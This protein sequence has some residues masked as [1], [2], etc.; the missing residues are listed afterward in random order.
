MLAAN[1]YYVRRRPFFCSS[2]PFYEY[3]CDCAFRVCLE[4]NFGSCA[5]IN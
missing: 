3:K 2:S 4:F 5:Y 1:V